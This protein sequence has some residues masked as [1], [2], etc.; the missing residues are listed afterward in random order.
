[1]KEEDKVELYGGRNFTG[2]VSRDLREMLRESLARLGR[3]VTGTVSRDFGE[4][5]QGQSHENE[6]SYC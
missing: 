2:T 4:L 3:D 6:Q 5:L 1:M